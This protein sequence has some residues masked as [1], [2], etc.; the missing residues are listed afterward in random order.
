MRSI[1]YAGSVTNATR[2]TE[3]SMGYSGL[4]AELK[5]I[6]SVSEQIES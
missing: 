3:V 2:V 1:T 5:T 4:I 6:V